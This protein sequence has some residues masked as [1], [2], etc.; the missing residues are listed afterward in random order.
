[1]YTLRQ[2]LGVVAL[3]APWNFPIAIPAWKIA[4]A[5]VSGNTGRL[6]AGLAGA[7]DVGAARQGSRAGRH[8]EGRA[9]PRDRIGQR[10]RHPARRAPGRA[11]HLVHRLRCRRPDIAKIGAERLARVQLE[12]GGKNPTIV[13][14]DADLDV[15]VDC[16]LNAAFFSTGQ[17][18]TATSRAIVER[19]I[20]KRSSNGWC[21]DRRAEDRR[22]ARPGH[23]ARSGDR[24][25]PARDDDALSRHR[26]RG[27][28]HARARRRAPVRPVRMRTA[29]SAVPRS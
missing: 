29:G 4:P 11:R 21:A 27:R 15:A 7:A 1:M 25:T 19:P 2:P 16:V 13:L 23:R 18:C 6:Q 9:Q 3:I 12:M 22:S 17:R 5:L 28:R 14:A 10:R 8:P 26:P 24:R 20:V